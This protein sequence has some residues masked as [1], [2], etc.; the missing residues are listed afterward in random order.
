M[1]RGAQG[2]LGG[3]GLVFGQDF[4][5]GAALD[6][7]DDG[8]A[9]A[10]RQQ[11][12]LPG[13][14]GFLG[15]DIHRRAAM[16]HGGLD[17]GVIRIKARVA[18]GFETIPHAF[19]HR[20]EFSRHHHGIGALVGIA[21]M[22]FLATA[23]R[24]QLGAALVCAHDL[25]QGRLADDGKRGP[26]ILRFQVVQQAPNAGAA[27]FFVIRQRE[28]DWPSQFRFRDFRRQPQ[29][30]S[31]KP[32][33][34]TG[35]AAIQIAIPHFRLERIAGP[36]L[37]VHRHHIGMAA[38]HIAAVHFLVFEGR[39]DGGKKI[40]LLAGGVIAAAAPR[41]GLLQQALRKI[42]QRQVGIAAGGVKANQVLDQVQR[43]HRVGLSYRSARL[44]GL[45]IMLRNSRR[46]SECSRKAP[47][48]LDV[49]MVTPVLWTPRVVM[50]WCA[51]SITTAT[52]LGC[53]TF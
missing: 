30:G 10:A 47:I 14:F 46:V 4:G 24:G 25:H 26:D 22:A 51:A 3:A 40:G 23:A 45:P 53:S 28:V 36:V 7:F 8:V 21:G 37:A 11:P 41:A 19:Q 49:T 1:Q 52:P 50:H 17:R 48:M 12:V 6:S 20:H 16:D 2:G 13:H 38:Q 42:N 9:V 35:A 34:V 31:D 15:Q 18:V 29:R 27:D 39:P 44:A 33:H 32:L 5:I 43:G